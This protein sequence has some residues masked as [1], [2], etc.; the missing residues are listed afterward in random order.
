[1][2]SFEQWCEFFAD[3]E[4]DPSAPIIGLTLCDYILASC[5]LEECRECQDRQE[6]VLSKAPPENSG[7]DVGM[8]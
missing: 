5:H 8:N 4:A 1:M 7:N 3:I 2:R 6:R